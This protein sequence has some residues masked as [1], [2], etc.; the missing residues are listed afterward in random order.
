MS[1]PTFCLARHSW[2]GSELCV[3]CYL[4]LHFPRWVKLRVCRDHC[5]YSGT[6]KLLW[7]GRFALGCSVLNAKA[8]RIT[9]CHL[10][11]V[12]NGAWIH[13]NINGLSKRD[14]MSFVEASQKRSTAY[15]F[16]LYLCLQVQLCIVFKKNKT[17]LY[18]TLQK[19]SP[20]KLK[21]RTGNTRHLFHLNFN[22]E[23]PLNI[24]E[25]LMKTPYGDIKI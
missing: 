7:S 24:Y 15:N 13:A 18:C 20:I 6:T 21:K 11:A 17:L 23:S 1:R 2:W 22:R 16:V 5:S 3:M 25:N 14:Q 10:S 4:R 9:P 8:S 19:C 12:L